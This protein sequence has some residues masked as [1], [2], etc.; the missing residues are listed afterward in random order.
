MAGGQMQAL[1]TMEI[2]DDVVGCEGSGGALGHP[3]VYLNL[4]AH[5][6]IECPYCGRHYV[7]KPGAKR[8]GGH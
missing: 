6:E 8:G 4:G 5:G 2:E 3:R 7:K 1:E